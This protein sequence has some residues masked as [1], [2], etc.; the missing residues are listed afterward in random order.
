MNVKEKIKEREDAVSQAQED[1]I[2]IPVVEIFRQIRKYFLIWV[3]LAVV[4]SALVFSAFLLKNFS[5]ITPITAMVGF[6]YDGIELGLDPNGN[7]FDG[8]SIKNVSVVQ[9]TITE[10]G[11]DSTL[12]ETIRNGIS[13]FSVIPSDT[14]DEI[15]AY[16]NIF[17]ETHSIDSAQKLMNVS[18]FS[19]TFIIEFDYSQTGLSYSKAINFLNSLLKNYKF[20]FMQTYNIIEVFGQELASI[21]YT[22]YDYAQI[23]DIFSNTL[24]SLKDYVDT[25]A[26]ED[27]SKFRSSETGYSFFDLTKSINILQTVNLPYLSSYIQANNITNDKDALISY[28]EYCIETFTRSLES[29]QKNLDTIVD[30]IENYQKDPIL[31]M[32]SND[33]TSMTLT[34]ASDEYDNLIKQK[35]S[36]Q[37]IISSYETQIS[38]YESRLSKIKKGIVGT[39]AKMEKA[40]ALIEDFSTKIN[41]IIDIVYTTCNEYYETIVLKDSYKV[42]VPASSS[43]SSESSDTISSMMRY[44]LIIEALLV[45]VY[46]VFA[47][48]RAFIVTHYKI[49]LSN[50]IGEDDSD[51][52]TNDDTEEE[53]KKK[54]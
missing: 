38:E 51:E 19:S 9:T 21:N 18:Y 37:S 6:Y 5:S 45:V 20:Y 41:D 43:L 12:L 16:Q 32:N 53:T 28:Y 31:I 2:T 52:E 50:A 54:S 44:L 27:I 10:M 24:T 26:D 34:Q 46:L 8:N 14:I 42:L 17:N 13:V 7:E 11:I 29:E 47:T 30:S 33:D 15:T 3:I 49:V 22:D 48:V 4:C 25:L 39:S 35:I 23:V 36:A 40:D 1:T